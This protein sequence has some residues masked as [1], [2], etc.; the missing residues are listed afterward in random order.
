M[1]W[2]GDGVEDGGEG[3]SHVVGRSLG[4]AGPPPGGGLHIVGVASSCDWSP[5][6]GRGSL[7][8]RALTAW[9]WLPPRAGHRGVGVASPGGGSSRREAEPGQGEGG[10]PGP[11]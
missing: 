7:W 11:W 3:A 5:R 4:G 1:S 2:S 9:A 8:G 10:V 6:R